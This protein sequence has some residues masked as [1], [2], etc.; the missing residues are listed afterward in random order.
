MDLDLDLCLHHHR[1]PDLGT[2][3]QLRAVEAARR[4]A[5]N[6]V[7]LAVD[8][9]R[10]SD[11]ARVAAEARGPAVVAQD[12]DWALTGHAIVVL[13]KEAP[14][15]RLHAEHVEVIAG[16]EIAP[17]ATQCAAGIDVHRGR[18]E[19]NDAVECHVPVTYVAVVGE[20]RARPPTALHEE[21]AIRPRDRERPK[22][23]GVDDTEDRRIRADAERQREDRDGRESRAARKRTEC[24]AK[25]GHQSF[26]I[27]LLRDSRKGRKEPTQGSTSSGRVR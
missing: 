8:T 1:R 16:G 6:R 4:D 13:M 26:H 11:D 22:R 3:E 12:R 19:A 2:V 5:K 9:D 27:C 24:V 15:H 14:S 20:G 18:T 23:D 10:R 25:I 7:R 17:R 21:H